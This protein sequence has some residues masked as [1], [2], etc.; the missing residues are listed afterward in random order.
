MNKQTIRILVIGAGHMGISH[1]RAYSKLAGF[2]I[3]GVVTRSLGSS[4]DMV[5]ELGPI[6][7]YVDFNKAL[8]R[9]QTRC[10]FH[11]FLYRNPL[12]LHHCRP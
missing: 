1:A 9:N 2:E 5:E 12:S 6:P 4:Q 11:F 7:Q 3:C 10:R 8:E